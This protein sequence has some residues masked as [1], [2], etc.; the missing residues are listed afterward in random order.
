MEMVW[1]LQYSWFGKA[2]SG[3]VQTDKRSIAEDYFNM[4]SLINEREQIYYQIIQ[5]SPNANQAFKTKN[6]Q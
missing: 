4:T 5:N 1:L 2:T 6:I 3:V